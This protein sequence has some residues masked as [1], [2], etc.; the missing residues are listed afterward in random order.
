M[1]RANGD[2]TGW[3]PVPVCAFCIENL[4]ITAGGR[5]YLKGLPLGR[6]K[7]YVTA[8][9]IKTPPVLEKDDLIE[10]IIKA[11]VRCAVDYYPYVETD[12]D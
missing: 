5:N 12:V 3:D 4:N 9:N 2:S 6:L 10:A 1:P 7:R 11:R 8:Y